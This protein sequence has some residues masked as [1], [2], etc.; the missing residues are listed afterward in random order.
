MTQY[1]SHK[2]GTC[3]FFSLSCNRFEVAFNFLPP[4]PTIFD[5][6][7]SCHLLEKFS[8]TRFSGFW[9]PIATLLSKGT[10]LLEFL[11]SIILFGQSWKPSS[12]C[13]GYQPTGSFGSWLVKTSIQ[14][15]R[16]SVLFLANIERKFQSCLAAGCFFA[17]TS[18][19]PLWLCNIGGKPHKDEN[20]RKVCKKAYFK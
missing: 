7:P 18:W 12:G 9:S 16:N 14:P 1:F 2:T 20:L 19:V 15:V 10:A 5:K 13:V 11:P 3:N 8:R 6:Y 17:P 4:Y